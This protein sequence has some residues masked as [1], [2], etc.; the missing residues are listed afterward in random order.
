MVKGKRLIEKVWW[1]I[2]PVFITLFIPLQMAVWEMIPFNRPL[3]SFFTLYAKNALISPFHFSSFWGVIL[4]LLTI[5]FLGVGY[6]LSKK[7]SVAIR[8][9]V[10]IITAITGYY[11]SAALISLLV[12]M[13]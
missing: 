2:P 11:I 10:P 8:I 5:A 12:F 3:S 6:Y 13:Y 7:W 1:M 4:T 9:V